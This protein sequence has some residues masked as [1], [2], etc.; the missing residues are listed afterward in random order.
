MSYDKNSPY[1]RRRPN[2][3]KTKTKPTS[4]EATFVRLVNQSNANV[5]VG[6]Q[7]IHQQDNLRQENKQCRKLNRKKQN[8]KE[9]RV[10][11]K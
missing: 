8:E 7:N 3:S 6:K 1:P 11:V 4:E 2:P 9:G 10:Q 5:L